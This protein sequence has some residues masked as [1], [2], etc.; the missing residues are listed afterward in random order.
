MSTQWKDILKDSLERYYK[1]EE[2]A[3]DIIE[4]IEALLI[5]KQ[6]EKTAI[7]YALKEIDSKLMRLLRKNEDN[8][9]K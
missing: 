3:E 4:W 7:L 5:E 1:G 8:P 9:R 2:S 6:Y